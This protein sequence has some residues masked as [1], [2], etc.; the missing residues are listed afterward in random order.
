MKPRILFI[1]HLPPPVH[2]AAMVGQYIQNSN[3]INEQFNTD[4]VNLSTSTQLNEIGKGGVRKLWQL[5]KIQARVVK[6]LLLNKYDLCYM[7]LTAGT[8]GFYKDFL[9]VVILKLFNKKIIYHFHNKGVERNSQNK[10]NDFLYKI[11]FKNTKSVLLSRCLYGDIAR[12]VQKENVFYCYNGIPVLNHN[13]IDRRTVND[14]KT[15]ILFLSNM[16]VEKGV[17]VLL[18][19]CKLL[20]ERKLNF[21]CHF[22]GPWSEITETDFAQAVENYQLSDHVFYH[23]KKY[24]KEKEAFFLLTDIFV[25]PTY[26]HNECFPLV[27]LEA[28]QYKLPI[29]STFEGGIEDIVLDNKTGFLVKQKD[30]YELAIKI[31]YLIIN[32]DI[33]AKMGVKGNQRFD[34]LF[35]NE[36]FEQRFKNVLEASL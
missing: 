8:P 3:L 12:Y 34:S 21:E 19:A 30:A 33:S 36:I 22:V 14:K 24:G 28:M 32:P 13:P 35:T 15:K 11:A 2:G 5:A 1:L 31:E 9:V 29:I 26:Y 18:E 25:F 7:T 4:Y 10:L 16:M 20:H 27:L 6:C 23:G 17:Y